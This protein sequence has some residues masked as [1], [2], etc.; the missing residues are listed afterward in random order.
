MRDIVHECGV[1]LDGCSGRKIRAAL[2]QKGGHSRRREGYPGGVYGWKIY[3]RDRGTR[4]RQARFASSL[5]KTCLGKS[6]QKSGAGEREANARER[7]MVRCIVNDITYFVSH[8]LPST[9]RAD[10]QEMI[11]SSSQFTTTPLATPIPLRSRHT[12]TMQRFFFLG[13]SETGSSADSLFFFFVRPFCSPGTAETDAHFPGSDSDSRIPITPNTQ[14]GYFP[15]ETLG[16][17][18]TCSSSGN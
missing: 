10:R 17:R 15:S 8:S 6:T 5:G 18:D 1:A 14:D 3:H 4:A 13:D 7:A 12:L 16:W 9:L 2:K 11:G